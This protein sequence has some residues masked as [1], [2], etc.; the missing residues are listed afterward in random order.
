M[1]FWACVE[2]LSDAFAVVAS[3]YNRLH[4]LEEQQDSFTDD[5]RVSA[6]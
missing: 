1:H 6:L 2:E 4:V 3:H 5:R